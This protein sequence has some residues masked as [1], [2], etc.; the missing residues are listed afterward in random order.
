MTERKRITEEDERNTHKGEFMAKVEKAAMELFNHTGCKPLTISFVW[1]R[2]QV[3]EDEI[4]NDMGLKEDDL[5]V[6]V[7][8]VSLS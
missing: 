3:P 8:N 4:M 6:R 1:S 2:D 5:K 7:E